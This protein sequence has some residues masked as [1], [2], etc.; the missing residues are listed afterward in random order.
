MKPV[1]D[2]FSATGR[3]NRKRYWVNYFVLPVLVM[4]AIFGLGL[5]TQSKA[6]GWLLILSSFVLG[7]ASICAGIKRLHD[8]GR[9]G[10]FYLVLY[11]P[12][13][14]FWPLVE[15]LFLQGTEGTNRF[16]TNPLGTAPTRPMISANAAT[17]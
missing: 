12:I 6:I 14:Q 8:R 11:V 16:G 15:I 9:S 10:W 3:M 1:L 2:Y 13:V 17:V 4:L 7:V 5:L